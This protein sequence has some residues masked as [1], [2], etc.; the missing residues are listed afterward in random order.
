[1]RLHNVARIALAIYGVYEIGNKILEAY[2]KKA[3]DYI[4][5]YNP[6]TTD[7]MVKGKT[8]KET[9]ELYLRLKDI[10]E[11]FD[12]LSVQDVADSIE[13]ITGARDAS[14]DNLPDKNLYGW[15][16]DWVDVEFVDINGETWIKLG[17]PFHFAQ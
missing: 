6:Y 17:R 11:K 7:I 2:G 12:Q 14:I 10:Y 4:P 16:N 15:E 1:M 8:S 5:S 3:E 9:M 13:V